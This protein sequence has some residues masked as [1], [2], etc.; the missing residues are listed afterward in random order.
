MSI[1]YV[2]QP[3][4][5]DYLISNGCWVA[6]VDGVWYTNDDAKVTTLISNYV[7]GSGDAPKQV[8]LVQLKKY[9]SFVKKYDTANTA[10]SQLDT[11]DMF[12]LDLV[13]QWNQGV[14]IDI[15]SPLST[16]IKTAASMTDSDYAY[17]FLYSV[18]LQ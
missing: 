15:E 3:G 7:P 9:L 13:L 16:F 1:Q 8:Q 4:L 10:I 6:N 17:A 11:S 18:N 5:K 2:D 14:T 12:N